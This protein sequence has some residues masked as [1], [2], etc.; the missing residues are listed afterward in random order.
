[1]VAPTLFSDVALNQV[2]ICFYVCGC[3]WVISYN[4][5]RISHKQAITTCYMDHLLWLK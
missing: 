3:W 4:S 1:M 2:Y 5:A